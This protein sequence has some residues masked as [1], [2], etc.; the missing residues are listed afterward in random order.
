MQHII[1]AVPFLPIDLRD[2]TG[3]LLKVG[4]ITVNESYLKVFIGSKL[5]I[6]IGLSARFEPIFT[7]FARDLSRYIHSVYEL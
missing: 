1:F 4:R 3:Q 7:I 6:F 5:R 2:Q